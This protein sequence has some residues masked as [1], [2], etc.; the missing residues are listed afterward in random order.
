[1]ATNIL[2]AKRTKYVSVKEFMEIFSLKKTQAY[3]LVNEPEFPKIRMGE[4]LIRIPLDD[5]IQYIE[6]RYN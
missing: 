6:K 3:D 5:A 2:S 1:M 4:K